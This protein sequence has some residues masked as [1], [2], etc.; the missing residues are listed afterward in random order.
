M[1]NY[2]EVLRAIRALIHDESPGVDISKLLF[3]HGCTY[4]LSKT[5]L[6][7]QF[8]QKL[9]FKK[10]LNHAIVD[11]RY[12]TCATV[13][14][15][16][17]QK[18]IPYAIIKGAVLSSVAYEDPYCRRSGDVDLLVERCNIDAVKE[19]MF[20]NGFVQ[21]WATK[22]GI[23]KFSR[24]ELLF[25]S[26]MSHQTAPF[27]KKTENAIC[28]YVDVDI[29]L[30]IM[31]GESVQKADMEFVLKHTEPF[32]L[33]GVSFRK[34]S[35]EMEFIQL[36]LHH[37]KDLNSIYLLY[38]RNIRLSH[39]CDIYFYLHNHPLEIESLKTLCKDLNV[40]EYVY[41]CL[42]YT[43][44]IFDVDFLQSWLQILYTPEADVLI[45]S[46]GLIPEERRRWKI[47]FYERIF[48]K[49]LHEYLQANLTQADFDKID[50]NKKFL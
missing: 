4:L 12:Q 15:Q 6:D 2:E 31:W 26:A 34:L 45:D 22:D 44:K 35:A 8:T 1:S 38:Q 21:G 3:E 46:F 25:Y 40:C 42:Y 29:N 47:D 28:P 17:E 7:P 30:D 10:L 32:T 23:E 27:V 11:T 24:K 33:C 19:V 50:I 13:F 16:L 39:F 49:S 36:C 14:K 43:N 48:G 5:T 41:Y 18:Q 9:Q 20:Q 37:Y